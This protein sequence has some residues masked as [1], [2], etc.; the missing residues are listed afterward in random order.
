MSRIHWHRGKPPAVLGAQRLLVVAHVRTQ[1]D[2]TEDP[3][4]ELF[5]SHFSKG[6]DAPVSARVSGMP[7]HR[8]PLKI[9][10]WAEINLPEGVELKALTN[11][12]FYG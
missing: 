1:Y 9:E 3:R 5:I 4:P 6:E 10:Y 11:V 8:P 7:A 12:D 2:A